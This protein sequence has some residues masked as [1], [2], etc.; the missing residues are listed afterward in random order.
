MKMTG[1]YLTCI[2]GPIVMQACSGG[3]DTQAPVSP[4]D[5]EHAEIIKND[6]FAIIS[7]QD[8]P[9]DR[10]VSYDARDKLDYVTTCETG[11]KYRAHVSEDGEVHVK[12]HQRAE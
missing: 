9:C 3:E 2:V 8:S 7:L 10:V 11:K 12:P 5:T 4:D 1:R 6:S